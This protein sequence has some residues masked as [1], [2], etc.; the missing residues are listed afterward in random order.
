M[1]RTINSVI[2][3]LCIVIITISMYKISAKAEEQNLIRVGFPQVEGFTEKIEGKYSGYAY[4]YLRE[5]SIYT[6][7]KYEF[8]EKDLNELKEDLKNGDIDILPGV[9][10][11]PENILI[12]DF[13]KYSSGYTY[14]TLV[15]P[16]YY[17]SFLPSTSAILDGIKVGYLKDETESI[18][19]FES[20]CVHNN[21]KDAES[22]EYDLKG[23]YTELLNK[24]HTGEVHA[25]LGRDL[26]EG[27]NDVIAKFGGI[28]HYFATTKGKKD[29]IDKLNY[30]IY[31]INEANPSFEQNLYNKYLNKDNKNI[32]ILNKDETSIIKEI[33]PLRVAYIEGYRPIQYYDKENNEPS[34]IFIDVLRL[35]SKKSN[36]KFD[37]IGVKKYDE[38]YKLLKD[39]KIDIIVGA[40]NNY[41][42]AD[43]N[44]FL[45]TK[46][47][48]S[49]DIVKVVNNKYTNENSKEIIALP[50]GHGHLEFDGD[51][52]IVYYNTVE[53]CLQAVSEYKASCTY[54][55]P[56]SMA[57]YIASDFYNNLKVITNV[58]E[59][60]VALGISKDLDEQIR[61]IL[62]KSIYSLSKNEIQSIINS[63]TINFRESASLKKFF[64]E[65]LVLCCSILLIILMLVFIIIKMKFDKVK[66]SRRVLF[67]KTQIDSLTGVF[68]REGCENKIKEY[69]KKDIKEFYYAFIIID[70]DNFKQVNDK[71]GH[72]VGDNLLKEFSSIMK[73]NFRNIDVISR[74][75]GDEFIIFM[76]NINDSNLDIV[77][78]KLKFLCNTM[79]KNIHID[80]LEQEISLS[81]G[82]VISK[83]NADFNE[84]Y[85][86]ADK[87]LYE[88]KYSG[89][90]GYK[91]SLKQ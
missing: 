76:E 55:N 72:K 16:K 89:R 70:I 9:L 43:E 32:L 86:Q 17:D 71:F 15:S 84:L 65:N 54:G 81:I 90:N 44:N 40:I 27:N 37:Y 88:V 66:E 47:Y 78:K 35:I 28:Q 74:L 48:L 22:I 79:N 4:E 11:K 82:A 1:K 61:T 46:A 21:I 2:I 68:N 23:G 91:Y 19:D 57:N 52:E 80:N 3:T 59:I 12:Y 33:K 30:S 25:V 7:W 60:E 45:L 51:Y 8:I 63:N 75:G 29:I 36:L 53:E 39:K 14:T 24:V 5:I 42:I 49:F 13:P 87:L 67:E 10:K 18:D 58:N 26:L 56:Y 69:L 85:I 31:Q 77:E 6:G 83:G 41:D 73:E 34:G 20:F 64:F 62:H 50:I 38:A